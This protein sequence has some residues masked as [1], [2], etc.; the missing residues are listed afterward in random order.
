M[1]ISEHKRPLGL[2][3]FLGSITYPTIQLIFHKQPDPATLL[4]TVIGFFVFI[5]LD[6]FQQAETI[7]KLE[8]TVKQLTAPYVQRMSSIDAFEY[9]CEKLKSAKR[10]YNTSFT[11]DQYFVNN[12]LYRRWIQSIV[13][14]VADHKCVVT[15]VM[16]S[17]DRYEALRDTFKKYK[18]PEKWYYIATIATDLNKL[19]NIPL[20]EIVLFDYGADRK[21]VI[22]G[23]ASS[24]FHS[25]DCFLRAYP[26]RPDCL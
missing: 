5:V 20:I 23:W 11:V 1:R 24:T 22:F 2:L 25:I 4:L 9:C 13:K 12:P 21:E 26:N 19:H 18:M 14:G 15:E 7:E 10:M 17:R 8:A 3:V 6:H 16:L